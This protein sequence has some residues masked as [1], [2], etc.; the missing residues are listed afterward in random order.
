V[1]DG[2]VLVDVS[3]VEG[4]VN[5]HLAARHLEPE[6]G[7]SEAAADAEDDVGIVQELVDRP[8]PR[9]PAG[10]EGEGVI[11]GKRALSLQAGGDRDAEQL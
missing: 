8:G 6:H 1:L 5:D 4:R 11:L 9:P 2:D 3:R 10:A 7:E